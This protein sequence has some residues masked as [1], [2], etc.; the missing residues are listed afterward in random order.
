MCVSDVR[1][2]LTGV[3]TDSA[4][5]LGI[6]TAEWGRANGRGRRTGFCRRNSVQEIAP[7]NKI[8]ISGWV[9]WIA[10]DGS[11]RK[12]GRGSNG[13]DR[14]MSAPHTQKRHHTYTHLH[15]NNTHPN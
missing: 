15:T 9:G 13:R 11:E 10:E 3:L 5:R 14:I 12:G 6:V 4:M 2:Q 8:M 7:P 1:R